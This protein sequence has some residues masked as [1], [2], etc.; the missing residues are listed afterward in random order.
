[1]TATGVD[2][3]GS[4]ARPGPAIWSAAGSAVALAVVVVVVLRRI[5][6]RRS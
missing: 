5:R 4:G 3:G 2:T 6:A 1:M